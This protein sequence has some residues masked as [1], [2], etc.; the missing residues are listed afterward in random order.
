MNIVWTSIQYEENKWLICG[1]FKVIGR[2]LGQDGQCFLCEWN[3]RAKEKHWTVR[4]CPEQ[5]EFVPGSKTSWI[6]HLYTPK[7]SCFHNC[8][9]NWVWWS[10]LQR[11]LTQ[12]R[13]C[14][15]YLS[16]KFPFITVE[17]L[18]TGIFTG[19]IFQKLMKKIFEKT[20]NTREKRSMNHLLICYRK[21]Y[22]ELHTYKLQDY[23]W[24]N[25]G[26]LQEVGLQYEGWSSLCTL[27]YCLLFGKCETI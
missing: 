27:Q 4:G 18:K 19:Y 17:T 14:F 25:A 23:C 10:S 13:P 9:L 24:T 11:V 8:I 15:N 5:K 20:M 26:K 16:M 1:D 22:G 6:K 12:D 21:F 2:L 7:R 3:S